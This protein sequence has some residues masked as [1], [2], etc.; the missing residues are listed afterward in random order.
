VARIVV[1]RQAAEP[2]DLTHHAIAAFIDL[3]RDAGHAVDIVHG[4]RDLPPADLAILHVDLSVVPP[5]YRDAA[6][7]YPRVLN[8]A[9]VDIRKR[10]VSRILLARDSDWPG[11][12]LVKSDLN[13]S[14][15]PEWRLRGRYLELGRDVPQVPEPVNPKV[16]RSLATV[17]ED[18]WA[19]PFLVVERFIPEREGENYA[20]RHWIFLGDRERCKRCLSPDPI[21][22]G[23][24]IVA[25]EDAPV[26]DEIRSERKRLGL[27]FGKMDFIV[28]D[29]RPFLFDA[30]KTPGPV[31][32]SAEGGLAEH[33]AGGIDTFLAETARTV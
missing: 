12:V 32:D 11:R 31:P 33:L 23:S 7:R 1:I 5:A 9:A 21:I 28:R 3:W 18:V 22:K 8:G 14:G 26:P 10:R 13:C 20:I 15:W 27:D 16:Y 19:D 4:I 17:P 30:N 25:V 29:G 6:K 24:N 2:T